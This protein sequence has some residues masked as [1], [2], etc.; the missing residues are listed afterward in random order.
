MIA[1]NLNFQRDWVK[2]PFFE[3]YPFEFVFARNFH[4]VGISSHSSYRFFIDCYP[5][6]FS[7]V[8]EKSYE[9][10]GHI[11]EGYSDFDFGD[12]EV[13]E[14]KNHV[15]DRMANGRQR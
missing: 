5:Y 8:F 6:S 4:S 10:N 9:I 7:E 15:T 13:L 2:I 3:I 11:D 1:S 14:Y 12:I